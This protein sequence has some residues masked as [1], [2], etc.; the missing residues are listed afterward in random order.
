MIKARQL[1]KA[2]S[3]YCENESSWIDVDEHIRI[4]F[5]RPNLEVYCSIHVYI[6]DIEV[7]FASDRGLFGVTVDRIYRVPRGASKQINSW[8]FDILKAKG[9]ILSTRKRKALSLKKS[10]REKLRNLYK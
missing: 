6:D 2:A 7:L 10:N 3:A 8:S 9:H 1:L 4:R 5:F